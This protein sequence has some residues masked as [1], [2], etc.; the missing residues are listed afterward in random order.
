MN[1]NFLSRLVMLLGA[2]VL[3][4]N[5]AW[6]AVTSLTLPKTW[7]ESDGKDAYTE[8]LGCTLNGL[9]TDY[10]SAPKLKFDTQDDYMIIQVE[11]APGSISFNIKGN[12]VSGTYSFKVQESSDGTS[13]TD[14]LNITSV[15]G[16]STNKSTNLKSTTRYIKLIYA[17]KASGNMGVGGISITK[18]S[19]GGEEGENTI[20]YN[21]NS[22]SSY[23]TGFP[24]ATGTSTSTPTEFTIG[25]HSLIISAPN[26]YYIINN[27][28]NTSRA[29]FFGQTKAANG[30]PSEGTA[31]LEFPAIEG[32]KLI[33]VGVTNASG[34][35]GSVSLNI[36]TT[37]WTAISTSQSTV[38]GSKTELTFEL[39]NPV[40]NTAY[41]LAAST[42]GKN[43]QLD[44]IVL[45]Y[46]EATTPSYT[47][48]DNLTNVTADGGN[49][50]ETDGTKDITL[51]YI[52]NQGYI[53]PD[54][55]T[56][57]V[58]GNTL[59]SSEYTWVA[60][61]DEGKLEIPAD[62]ITG[63]IVVTI[64]GVKQV[65]KLGDIT[66]P[67]ATNVTSTSATLTWDA[68]ANA[69]SYEVYV[70]DGDSYEK[71]E[72]VNTNSLTLNDLTAS[73][74]YM[75]T[76]Q[77][78]GDGVN[79]SDGDK[80]KDGEFSTPAATSKTIY[81]AE[82][83][84][85]WIEADAKF[86]VYSITTS[87]WQDHF[88]TKGTG[89][90]AGYYYDEVPISTEQV[91]FGRFNPSASSPSWETSQGF[92]S[93]TEN[94]TIGENDLFTPQYY[95]ENDPDKGKA[96]GSWS[97][98][99]QETYKVTLSKNESDYGSI[100]IDAET[101]NKIENIP[102]G[103][104][105]SADGNKLKVGN[106][107][108]TATA[109]SATA[110][111]TYSFDNWTWTGNV[112]SVESNI[113]ATAN[114]SRVVNRYTVGEITL[115]DCS[116]TS[117]TW[118][119][120][121]FEYGYEFDL[122]IAAPAGYRLNKTLTT[123]GCSASWTPELEENATSG[124]VHVKITGANSSLTI[125]TY[126]LKYTVTWM[127]NGVQQ[128][129]QTNIS[130]N[131]A[132]TMP[133]TNPEPCDAFH[134]FMGWTATENYTEAT[135]PGDLF[136]SAGDKKVTS[137]TT[138][139]AVYGQIGE[140]I[141]GGGE[142]ELKATLDLTDNTNWGFP[143]G[144]ANRANDEA[145][146]TSG[147][148]TIKVKGD[149]VFNSQGDIT[150][151]YYWHTTNKYLALGK[152]GAQITLPTFNF[153]VSKI[154]VTGKGGASAS[155]KQNIYVGETAVSTETTGAA[156]ENP[157]TALTNEYVINESYRAVGTEYIFKVTSAHNTQVTTI[158]IY[159]S[160]SSISYSS[161][162]T[163]CSNPTWTVT[164]DNQGHGAQ[165]AP[166]T[167]VEH[168]TTI[169]APAAPN[170]TGWAFGG[171][172][173]EPACTNAWDFANDKVTGNIT[174]YAKWTCG[175]KIAYNHG[176]AQDQQ[177][178]LEYDSEA[179]EMTATLSLSDNTIYYFH[180]TEGTWN[181]GLHEY[182]AMT[183]DNNGPE[184]LWNFQQSTD[185]YYDA[186][187]GIATTAAGDYT[188]HVVEEPHDT[189]VLLKAYVTYPASVA[190]TFDKQGK[191]DNE[192]LYT[193]PNSALVTLPTTPEAL[194]FRFDG[195]YNDQTCTSPWSSTEL[196]AADKTIYAK[197][198]ELRTTLYLNA[199]V[200]KTESAGEKFAVYYFTND[201]QN[202]GWSEFMTPYECDDA[203]YIT[204]IPQGYDKVNFVRL[205][206][207]CETPDWNDKWNQTSDKA[208]ADSWNKC[209][210]TS[211]GETN[212]DSPATYELY[213]APQK[214]ITFNDNGA[215]EGEA[216]ETINLDCG[217]SVTLPTMT[218][219][220]AHYTF[221]GWE[222]ASGTDYADGATIENV[223]ED[224]ALA[225]QWEA[226]PQ[227]TITFHVPEC[228]ATPSAITKYKDE[229]IDL[230]EITEPTI[231]NADYTFVGWSRIE[232]T[233]ADV[234]C[235]T[236][237][238]S[239][240]FSE[241]VNLYAI[242]SVGSEQ[243]T[244]E[245]KLSQMRD[246]TTYYAQGKS[247]NSGQNYLLASTKE[248]D[249]VVFGLED[250]MYLYYWDSNNSKQYVYKGSGNTDVNITSTKTDNNNNKWT[251]TS[252]DDG[253]IT[254]NTYSVTD[255][256]LSLNSTGTNSFKLYQNTGDAS[257]LTRHDIM[258]GQ[259]EYTSAPVCTP[260]LNSITVDATG[261]TKTTYR[262]HVD[263]TL[264]TEGIVVTA[265][266][267]YT[268]ETEEIELSSCQ[269]S[270][271]D[272]ETAGEQAIT[273]TYGDFQNTYNITITPTY[274][275]TYVGG[276][277]ATAV[278][279]DNTWYDAGDE[280]TVL[281]P[282]LMGKPNS[283]FQYWVYNEMQYNGGEKIT[284]PAS[285]I[286]FTA[287]WVAAITVTLHY[288]GYTTDCDQLM[289]GPQGSTITL[290][291]GKIVSGKTFEGWSDGVTTYQAGDE[292]TLTESTTLTASY[293]NWTLTLN[294]NG[295]TQTPEVP[296][297]GVVLPTTVPETAQGAVN[298]IFI[299]FTKTALEEA[300]TDLPADFIPAGSVYTP[301][302]AGE[303]L[304]ALYRQGDAEYKLIKDI[305]DLRLGAHAVLASIDED[306][307]MG[308]DFVLG[309]D[310]LP[311]IVVTKDGD[312]ETITFGKDVQE[313]VL[314]TS[315]EAGRDATYQ[316]TWVFQRSD[317]KK[318]ASPNRAGKITLGTNVS[319]G[320]SFRI[321]IDASGRAT[322][323]CV[324]N[325]N[326]NTLSM[327]D[328]G[329]FGCYNPNTIDA[330]DLAI[331]QHIGT[332]Y[333][334]TPSDVYRVKS[335]DMMNGRIDKND[336]YA[337]GESIDLSGYA[338][339]GYSTSN[340]YLVL[341]ETSRDTVSKTRGFRMPDYNVIDTLT[342]RAKQ[343]TIVFVVPEC[344]AS[345]PK[346]IKV[347]WNTADYALPNIANINSWNFVGWTKTA[348]ND[349]SEVHSEIFTTYT[350]PHVDRDTFYAIYSYDGLPT[351]GFVL[352]T[353]YN[354]TTYYLGE[355]VSGSTN[356]YF[357]AVTDKAQAL[358]LHN[359]GGKLYYQS[360]DTLAYLKANNSSS[361]YNLLT[362]NEAGATV[363]SIT[364]EDGKTSIK[365]TI[366]DQERY[367][368]FNYNSGTNPRYSIYTDR[369]NPVSEKALSYTTNP[370][371]AQYAYYFVSDA[372]NAEPEYVY[373][374]GQD[375]NVIPYSP[376]TGCD[377]KRFI[378]W[379]ETKV[380]ALQ[381]SA[382]SMVNIATQTYD[383]DVTL[384]A[385]YAAENG[386]KIVGDAPTT[387]DN[388]TAMGAFKTAQDSGMTSLNARYFYHNAELY[389][390]TLRLKNGKNL[391]SSYITT[392]LIRDLEKIQV[393]YNTD[394]TKPIVSI[395]SDGTIWTEISLNK[396]DE[397]YIATPDEQGDY[398]VAF[399]IKKSD[400]Q[401][402]SYSRI[403]SVTYTHNKQYWY[404]DYS[405]N[406]NTAET[407][408]ITYAES[409]ESAYQA[410]SIGEVIT[411]PTP[412][413]AGK[414]F[415][416]WTINGVNYDGD[417]SYK[418][419]HEVT[420]TAIWTDAQLVCTPA[421]LYVVSAKGKT[422]RSSQTIQISCP[423]ITEGTLQ[424]PADIENDN[425][426][427]HFVLE[428]ATAT[429]EG[430]NATLAVEYTPKKV[431]NMAVQEVALTIGDI[432]T[433][434]K[435][436][437]TCLPEDFV[438][439]HQGSGD[440]WYALPADITAFGTYTGY[441]ITVDGDNATAPQSAVYHLGAVTD[442][443]G[444][445]RLTPTDTTALLTSATESAKTKIKVGK[446]GDD[447]DNR[448]LWTLLTT[449]NSSFTFVNTVANNSLKFNNENKFG[450]FA[451]GAANDT[452]FRIFKVT[453]STI[454]IPITVT[455]WR[456][457]G[458]SFIPSVAIPTNNTFRLRV[459][460]VEKSDVTCAQS[461]SS[462]L[463]N[464]QTFEYDSQQPIRLEWYNNNQLVA[465]ATVVA[466]ARATGDIT[467]S[468][469]LTGDVDAK[470]LDIVVA[471]GSLTVDEKA[472]IHN[473][474][475]YPGATVAITNDTLTATTLSFHG[476]LTSTES[477]YDY[478]VPR[479][480]I[481]KENYTDA[482][483]YIKMQTHVY[484]YLNVNS[485]H[486]Y[487]FTVP[488][489][490]TIANIRYASKPN[491]E[492]KS[493]YGK[494]KAI[495]ISEYN[496]EA[497]GKGAA[498][499][500]KYWKDLSYSND[501]IPGVGYIIT[502]KKLKGESY[503]SLRIMM[504]VSDIDATTD[505][506][507][508]GAWGV[509]DEKIAWYNQGWNYIANPYTAMLAGSN[510]DDT[511]HAIQ[512]G[513]EIRYATIPSPTVD[514]YDQVPITDA[515]LKPF[516]GFFIQAGATGN[517]NFV[518]NI[519]NGAPAYLLAE[520]KPE[521]EA[522]ISLE[523]A[524]MRDRLGL[525]VGPKHTNDYEINADLTKELGSANDLR[526]WLMT[527]ET[528]MAYLAI[529]DET[530]RTL[531]PLNLRT[532]AEGEYTFSLRGSSRVEDLE[533]L[534]LFD[535]ELGTTTN[536][537]ES[538]YTFS[539]P[540]GAVE[541]R[542]ALSAIRQN[543][544]PTDIGGQADR[545]I[546]R[547]AE[548]LK[549]VK[550]GHIYIIVNGVTFNAEGKEVTK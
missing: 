376:K 184:N 162:S 192:I 40:A 509:D 507:A 104:S 453:T 360:A 523:G 83:F 502:A 303:T 389:D 352:S 527:G 190:V 275:V 34:C 42:N 237:E 74:D 397:I 253:K 489:K 53:L 106:T 415:V 449:D 440:K 309:Q 483:G 374:L 416:G 142:E 58:G 78:K 23:P 326:I 328:N 98:Y 399:S 441:E 4:C 159:G 18:Y 250:G 472:T 403:N 172:Y 521:Q 219:T 473:L 368:R 109:K 334:T 169:V 327:G 547:E 519:H 105:I 476:G 122:T 320:S 456:E 522:Y 121:T 244:G 491:T 314:T 234:T 239:I 145:S 279:S 152:S 137:N 497:R 17:T 56:V 235:P 465:T 133:S 251:L 426:K 170:A 364:T 161:Y 457:N 493:V 177:I 272:F 181:C 488:Y 407:A 65:V 387:T 249:G 150:N 322:A 329:A 70:M 396:V 69:S 71:T 260:V 546:G 143:A 284:M 448:S 373:E 337:E 197:W 46:E 114:F 482:P 146:F 139:Y 405:T 247:P 331:Y 461:G 442:D 351:T 414:H 429:E 221:M 187:C 236:L 8:A 245:F 2:I 323:Q 315:S 423:D 259:T 188:F 87:S 381:Q 291:A 157:S 484:Y 511:H 459:N 339:D 319:E 420:A 64:N 413:T 438:I 203:I 344:V 67:Q 545:R 321:A 398:Y 51:D 512:S 178:N 79:Y 97:T 163:T 273:V 175:W 447:T 330:P 543:K 487:P 316:G 384:Y 513:T 305:K 333:V 256:F 173:K 147:D 298:N 266:Y 113:T 185:G 211:F 365:T 241:N 524:A 231:N 238:T 338:N 205:N 149:G 432:S 233:T 62:K 101:A 370:V 171:W 325:Y 180:F 50:T 52:A 37:T 92:W 75:W 14:A 538:D 485:D 451:K 88:M 182:S 21:F 107:T 127:A 435:V 427:L 348:I 153:A 430:L 3:T 117:G 214:H 378:G 33:Q 10:S 506:V 452:L 263:N 516:Y 24:T 210:I 126:A 408:T 371:C 199:G 27:G 102:C 455:E 436:R 123:S 100:T 437:G 73:T 421:T 286:T 265:H 359:N 390:N 281:G 504:M 540:A 535:M 380:S 418:L 86:A 11:E 165:V 174:L 419:S 471:S 258:E 361:T 492:I 189:Y 80:Y 417:E 312:N 425:G 85:G 534:Y 13:Y 138:Y 288:E 394:N 362:T 433:T 57:Q 77:A 454:T 539:A 136:L 549:M 466:P 135:A 318:L 112:T 349:T 277:G 422:V 274:K 296:E 166:I 464:V 486:F 129:Q 254:L 503:A 498:T 204:T 183:K 424:T 218:R 30:S 480:Y 16:S 108:V 81:M 477:N 382:P 495:V 431:A 478:E 443:N 271:P 542:F 22:T 228:A 469:L 141:D 68:V 304:Y 341:G 1:N 474:D 386:G 164:F 220:K 517:Y 548:R 124:T 505:T 293:T 401:T 206:N 193:A 393:V 541:N 324:A 43:L 255:R 533:G 246:N 375:G 48:T 195:W 463:Y 536:L 385:V 529:D 32:K 44:N 6:G 95:N 63:N 356:R 96:H 76:V 501:L 308:K 332:K 336:Y 262:Q 132:L 55:I 379:S 310:T 550:D 229:V 168:N 41:R 531:I 350:I 19:S 216:M 388:V 317:N 94:L 160:G 200:W 15:T 20:T 530:A 276:E 428:N 289:S 226:I 125:G 343:D 269:F 467:L 131:A 278:P 391:D 285:N 140:I 515:D 103:T 119:T 301:A 410:T 39:S 496:G 264:T 402:Y 294:Y 411:L 544:A 111:Y 84:A 297:T 82:G 383:R 460:D 528:K 99:I 508:V 434:V 369:Q 72:T 268:D 354:E 340:R 9:G 342:N 93:Q 494:D 510:V 179:Q 248:A 372:E 243:P 300:I 526:A 346:D 155:V 363:W 212:S 156:T 444:H 404:S 445:I 514:G 167:N 490:T 537:I 367:L 282:G 439:A 38:N 36:F 31:Y 257:K 532:P 306:Y 299:G 222:D 481:Q 479:L 158:G 347:D 261:A 118:P 292:Y 287:Q 458:F 154:T 201:R 270:T 91:I 151:G 134:H 25:G 400:S 213:S 217:S 209:S 198:T 230:G 358:V 144:S 525:I 313:W 196:I 45:T 311:A 232:Q 29:L 61:G 470:N 35:A 202:T 54:A 366:N 252:C 345:K 302:A 475:I 357:R 462:N 224:I 267:L 12:S 130:Y 28:N 353:V 409:S 355:Y 89:C 90:L 446:I 223:T 307:A 5:V 468:A 191:G 377:A 207:T 47:I 26:A 110:Q 115:N 128:H 7:D 148:Y 242:Y 283:M 499:T 500:T 59:S 295:T 194:S 176:E 406:C 290:P 66:N 450:M 520:E 395:S 120:G 208:L 116:I 335:V 60:V 186:N 412:K 392:S 49:L 240:T 225:A 215:D 227:Y 518:K 280:V